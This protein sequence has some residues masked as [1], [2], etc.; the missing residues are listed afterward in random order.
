MAA[1]YFNI[2]ATVLQKYAET[3]KESGIVYPISK[4]YLIYAYEGEKN[5][6]LFG[7]FFSVSFVL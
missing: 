5:V 2:Y 4:V 3:K 7:G 1:L 6:K